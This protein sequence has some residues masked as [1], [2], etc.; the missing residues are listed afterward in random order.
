ML[1]AKAA[2]TPDG[3]PDAEKV[4][5]EL[6]TAGGSDDESG[7]RSGGAKLESPL[8]GL[9]ANVK[10]GGAV[11]VTAST[12]LSVTAPPVADVTVTL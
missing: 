2:V 3:S 4:T 1:D 8:T 12:A 7:L 11:T 10:L 9:A 6:N 5:G